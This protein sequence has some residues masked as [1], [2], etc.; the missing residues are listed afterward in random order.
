[1]P[2]YNIAKVSYKLSWSQLTQ[3]ILNS[4]KMMHAWHMP[5]IF[6]P[7]EMKSQDITM[8]STEQQSLE[9][10]FQRTEDY[11]NTS[12]AETLPPP[13]PDHGTKVATDNPPGHADEVQ[14]ENSHLSDLQTALE[15][16]NLL[17]SA[18]LASN[19]HLLHSVKIGWLQN[20][21]MF[22]FFDND[23]D[24]CL[25]LNIFLAC[26]LSSV[27]TYNKMRTVVMR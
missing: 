15:F 7:S 18:F 12:G 3:G 5:A 4:G 13:T 17:Q 24:L 14:S 19:H 6:A 8:G 9:D 25:G 22:S 20:S 1:M 2:V 16:I 26:L 11:N 21:L 10:C 27:D 23:P